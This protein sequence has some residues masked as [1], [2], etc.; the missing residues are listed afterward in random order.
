MYTYMCIHA[1]LHCKHNKNC[2]INLTF[3][4]WQIKPDVVHNFNF[5]IFVYM[6]SQKNE[7]NPFFIQSVYL[8]IQICI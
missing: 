7:Q 2:N 8:R 5:K 1:Y 6:P 3:H 4:Q